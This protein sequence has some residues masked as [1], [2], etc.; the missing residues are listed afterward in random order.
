MI[1]VDDAAFYVRSQNAYPN[2]LQEFG[3]IIEH[4]AALVD[5]RSGYLDPL[6]DCPEGGSLCTAPLVEVR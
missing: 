3:W 6:R 5:F 1:A 4:P 2:Q